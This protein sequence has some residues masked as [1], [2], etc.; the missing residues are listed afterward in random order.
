MKISLI[1]RQ[2]DI[3]RALRAKN[4]GEHS[5]ILENLDKG[6]IEPENIEPVCGII[7]E[8]YM[9]KGIEPSFEPNDYGR[10]L[11]GLLDVVNRPRLR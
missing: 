7:N 1:P 8:E 2:K 9:M 5:H 6:D 3:L 10:E 11:E 4:H